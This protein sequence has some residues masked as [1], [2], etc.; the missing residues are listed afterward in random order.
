MK[1]ISLYIENFGGLSGYSLEFSDGVTVIRE[2]NGFGKTTL[3][4]F[5]RAMF[6]GFP[7][8]GKF[9]EKDRRQRYTPWNGAKAGGN[10]VF[11]LNG[12]PYRIERTFGAEPRSDTFKLVDL[13]TGKKSDRFSREIGTELFQLDADS[14]ERSTYMPQ[15][16]EQ[17]SLTTAGIQ[18]KLSDLVEDANDVGSFDKAIGAL[19]SRR[20]TFIPY[21][22]SGGSV[23]E[24]AANITRLQQEL[25]RAVQQ[26]ESLELCRQEIEQLEARLEQDQLE[27]TEVREQIRL[28][29]EAAART[30]VR[31]QYED[32][33][34]RYQ[35]LAAE[36]AAV[37]QRYPRGIPP[38]T[39]TD[40][41]QKLSHHLAVLTA[42]ERTA[43][44]DLEAAVFVEEN[45]QRFEEHTPEPEELEANRRKWDE[46]VSL[47]TQARHAV[48]SDGEAKQFASL[49]AVFGSG[50]P[51]EGMLDELADRSRQLLKLKTALDSLTEDPAQLRQREDLELYFAAGIPEE[52]QLRSQQQVLAR[53]E[54][55]RQ[56][57]LQLAAAQPAPAPRK[58][59]SP[60]PL[61]LTLVLAA[62]GIGLGIAMLVM[63]S[64]L[65]GGIGLGV[66]LSAL[67]GAI[68][69]GMR[70]M[71]SRELSVAWSENRAR[72]E[73]NAAELTALEQAAADFIRQYSGAP[74]LNEGLREIR[75]HREQLLQL[76]ERQR[77]LEEKRSVLTAEER[78]LEA[79]LHQALSPYFGN[80]TD[81]DKCISSLRLGREKFLDLQSKKVAADRDA[82]AL[83]ALAQGYEA[84]LSEF[85]SPY[86]ENISS[87][88]FGQLLSELQRDAEHYR[89]AKAQAAQWQERKQQQEQAAQQCREELAEFFRRYGLEPAD[90]REQLQQLQNDRRILEEGTLRQMQLG[91][92]LEAFRTEN[93]AVLSAPADEA[94]YDPEELKRTEKQRNA[95]ITALT[96]QL[97]TC[98]QTQQSL[99]S[100]V[101]RIPELRDELDFWQEKKSGDQKKAQ[102]LDDTMEFLHRAKDSLSTSYLGPIRESFAGYLERLAGHKEQL[103]VSPDLDVQLERQG[104]A[105]E[106]A[107]FSA[108]QTDL[109]MLCMRLALVDA[110]FR[111]EKPFVILDDP[112]VN[113]DDARTAEALELLRELGRERQI[114]YLTCNSSRSL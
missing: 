82:E 52:A 47:L 91:K 113:L 7:R 90:D 13:T 106:M 3:A 14:F 34:S 22:G 15:L 58:S 68:F 85:L 38:Q 103:L 31:R 96:G 88:Q 21:R 67:M 53:W 102:T 63:R 114:L 87:G 100:Q 109:V 37:K 19:K 20:S 12:V 84:E 66:G 41:A 50:G 101:D 23:A 26:K 75:D 98:R 54:A 80:I 57:N 71:V 59:T 32:L 16:G 89:R 92:Q 46:Y 48:L 61:I 42:Q 73:R 56:E 4:E 111:E 76:R 51:D 77:I 69:L 55:L 9:L 83:T 11:E 35:K 65:L 33:S 74:D 40:D 78:R 81:F 10:L 5:I 94:T 95:E 97:L 36:N 49:A 86:F 104:Q 28:A 108:G 29:S 18:A 72:L 70:L 105:R 39:E 107:Y 24:A 27:I 45:R 62:A 25:D 2:P 17:S 110:L 6:Y 1:L 44:A 64:F 30:A 43:Q 60:V 112:F 99:R 79:G 93:E 8:K